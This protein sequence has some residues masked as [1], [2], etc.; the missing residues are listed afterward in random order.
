MV[1]QE[2]IEPSSKQGTAKLSTCLSLPLLSGDAKTKA[3]KRRRIL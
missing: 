2:G 3:T 1:D